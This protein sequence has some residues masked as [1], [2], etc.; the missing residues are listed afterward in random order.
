MNLLCVPLQLNCGL[1]YRLP[2]VLLNKRQAVYEDIDRWAYAVEHE[3]HNKIYKN[4]ECGRELDRRQ[5]L[6]VK[7]CRHLCELVDVACQ[8]SW[9][10]AFGVHGDSLNESQGT[11]YESWKGLADVIGEYVFFGELLCYVRQERQSR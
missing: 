4:R 9:V 1:A 2:V 7:L 8:H 11:R 3:D 5:F 10:S 6:L